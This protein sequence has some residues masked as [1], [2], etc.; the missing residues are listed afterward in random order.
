MILTYFCPVGTVSLA[1]DCSWPILGICCARSGE[2]SRLFGGLVISKPIIGLLS[3]VPI[4]IGV[5]QWLKRQPAASEVQ[6]VHESASAASTDQLE[7]SKQRGWTHLFKEVIT[8][9]LHPQ[10]YSVAAVTFANGG[11]NVGIYIPSLPA[12]T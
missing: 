5:S 7:P 11:D 1:A 3:L 2:Y 9:I 10:T 4:A 12:V 8:H 6:A